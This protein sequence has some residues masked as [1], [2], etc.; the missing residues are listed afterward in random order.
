MIIVQGNTIH[1]SCLCLAI[2][3]GGV[4]PRREAAIA[5]RVKRVREFSYSYQLRNKNRNIGEKMRTRCKATGVWK[6]NRVS[7]QVA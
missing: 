1:V 3:R 6:H 7:A 2:G 4:V 5:Q